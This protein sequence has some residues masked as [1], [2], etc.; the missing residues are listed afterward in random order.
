MST[1]KHT[2][3]DKGVYLKDLLLSF[4]GRVQ[5]FIHTHLLSYPLKGNQPNYSPII[6]TKT[7]FLLRPSNSP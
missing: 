4:D 5:K 1:L 2:R 7:L 6:F 3:G